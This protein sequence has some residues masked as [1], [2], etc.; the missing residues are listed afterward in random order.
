MRRFFTFLLCTLSSLGWAQSLSDHTSFQSSRAWNEQIDNRADIVM[1]YGVGG[2]PSDKESVNSLENRIKSW[3]EKGYQTQFM[4]GIA[5]G[6]YQDYFTGEWDGIPHLDEGQVELSGDTI[7]HGKMV[8]Y[9]VP[10]LNFLEYMKEVHIKRVIDAGIDV[11]YLEEPEF[12]ARAGY[13]ESFKREWEDYYGFPWR[14]QHE[15]AENTYLSNKLK[16]YLYYRALEEVCTFAKEYGKSLGRNIKCYVPTHSL[17]NYSQWQI[18]SPEASLASLPC[19]DGYI[20]QVWTGTSRVPNYYKGVLKER[21]FENAFLEYGCLESMT[22]PTGRRVYFLSDPIENAT[23]DWEDYKRGYEATFTA[24]LLYPDNNYFEVMPWP[25]RIYMKLYPKSASSTEKDYI[26]REYSTQM[27]VMIGALNH[28]P[29]SKNRVSGSQG[30]YVMMANSLMFQRTPEPIEDYEDPQLANFH[31]LALP[32]LKR[33][34]PVQI[35]HLE[36]AKYEENWKDAKVVLMTYSNMKPL[37]PE[38]HQ[39]IADWVREGGVLVYVSKDNDPFQNVQEWWNQEGNEYAHPADHLFRLM[40]IPAFPSEGKYRYGKG[41]VHVLR[42]DPKEFV[43]SG[44]DAQLLAAVRDAYEEDAQAGQLQYKNYLSLERGYYDLIAVLDESVSEEP[45]RKEGLFI[46]L[47]DPELPVLEYKRINPGQ[48]AFLINLE[49]VRYNGTPQILASASREYEISWDGRTYSFV[50]KAPK[51]TT[52]VMRIL[53]PKEPLSVS[54]GGKDTEWDWDERSHT[55][56]M[57]FENSPE[58]IKVVIR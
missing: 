50:S 33:G 7:W 2:N 12:W 6:G 43:M 8:P 47:F 44:R 28:M 35:M 18:V 27:Q 17:I 20:A 49:R 53:L 9:I 37:Q 29:C 14:A 23:R 39:Q 15:S 32:L 13:S 26:P 4:T 36:N 42:K 40:H 11:I 56:K 54:I 5:W 57:K 1:I 58:G 19:I 30:I 55:L 41:R 48:Q 21:I 52:N 45:L 24:E 25:E 3:K 34:V 46:D 38:A 31:G 10:S 16:Y 22:K 51:N